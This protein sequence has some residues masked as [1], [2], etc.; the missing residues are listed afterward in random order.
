MTKTSLVANVRLMRFI[1][2]HGECH[3][4]RSFI[5]ISEGKLLQKDHTN[6]FGLRKQMTLQLENLINEDPYVI[7]LKS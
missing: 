2:G 1:T 3:W 7:K 4:S 6:N 5:E